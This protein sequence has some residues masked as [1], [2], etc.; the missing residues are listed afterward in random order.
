MTSRAHLIC[1]VAIMAILLPARAAAYSVLTHE[2]IIDALWDTSIKPL[3]LA[4]FPKT[5]ELALSEA[6]AHAY[7][8][9]VIH[10]LGY[11]PFGSK[12]F[13]NLLH[14]V[15]TGDFVESLIRN[16]HDVNDYAF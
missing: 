11:Y 9:C 5:T 2:A 7:G 15:R 6:R 10:D 4:R 1:V 3:L 12:F 14:Y 8:G 13:S 16:S